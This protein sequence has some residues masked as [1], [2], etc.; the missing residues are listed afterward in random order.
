[1]IALLV[2]IN[3][4]IVIGFGIGRKWEKVKST[5]SDRWTK[6]KVFFSI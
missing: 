3:I 1:M 4:G 6:A 5:L 2:G